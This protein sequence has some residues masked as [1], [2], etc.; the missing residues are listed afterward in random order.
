MVSLVRIFGLAALGL[1][2]LGNAQAVNSVP[3]PTIPSTTDVAG[4]AA[5]NKGLLVSIT[6]NVSGCTAF[7]QGNLCG[8]GEIKVPYGQ[9][10]F[11]P[12][13]CRPNTAFIKCG[14][15]KEGTTVQCNAHLNFNSN[16]YSVEG[17]AGDACTLVTRA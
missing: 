13:L 15:R 1:A 10:V 11:R 2:S 9:T 6:N 8:F 17:I 7:V 14:G 5:N 4:A 12:A 16:K 3:H